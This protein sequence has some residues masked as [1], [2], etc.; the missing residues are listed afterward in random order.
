MEAESSEQACSSATGLRC[1]NHITVKNGLKMGAKRVAVLT[2]GGMDSSI[3]VVE[4]SRQGYEVFPVYI[5]HGLYW[6]KTEKGYLEQF[7][8]EVS[9][10]LIRPL[11]FL[12]LP[13]ADLYG[14][15]WSVSGAGVPDQNTADDAVYLPGRNLLLLAKLGVW[16]SENDVNLIALA[17]LKGNPFADNSDEFYRLTTD[18]INMALGSAIAVIRPFSTLSKDEVIKL[19]EQLPLSLTFSCIKPIDNLHC[20]VCNKCAERKLGYENLGLEDSTTYYS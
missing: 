15:H 11:T 17:P 19:G 3:L 10:P 14:K 2:S 4:L 16:C 13:V 7:L 8:G 5:E 1:L 18:A 6:E 12:Q 9:R 20:G